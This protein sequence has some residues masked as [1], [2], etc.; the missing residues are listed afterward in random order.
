MEEVNI[1]EIVSYFDKG[2]LKEILGIDKE[3]LSLKEIEKK[4]IDVLNIS[5]FFHKSNNHYYY[6]L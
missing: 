1:K 5:S 6:C 3:S 2:F 4:L